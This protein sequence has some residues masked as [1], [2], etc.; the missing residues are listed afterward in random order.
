MA[1]T[2]SVS[3]TDILS[4]NAVASDCGAGVNAA[5]LIDKC[6]DKGLVSYKGLE[7]KRLL[8]ENDDSLEEGFKSNVY[9]NL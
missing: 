3:K 2:Y 4:A 8:E 9:R 5:K 7:L 6:G 1:W